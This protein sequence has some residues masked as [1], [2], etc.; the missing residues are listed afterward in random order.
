M[1][2]FEHPRYEIT[3]SHTGGPVD[4][5]TGDENLLISVG[6]DNRINCFSFLREVDAPQVDDVAQPAAQE[7][8]LLVQHVE[9][10]SQ[11]LPSPTP[12]QELPTKVDT[13]LEQDFASEQQREHAVGNAVEAKVETKVAATAKAKKF[14]KAEVSEKGDEKS[15]E[16]EPAELPAD[17]AFQTEPKRR[18]KSST[19][20]KD[21]SRQK[22]KS[23]HRE[24]SRKHR[25][26]ES[27]SRV[28]TEADQVRLQRI[29]RPLGLF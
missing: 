16:E 9:P 1:S 11:R 10:E 6:S 8:Q 21:K 17:R 23:R 15:D 29:Y 5:I 25:S 26:R 12:G 3:P 28:S 13:K 7:E 14:A 19:K 27:H 22:E 4:L 18:R 2:L 20:D 24:K